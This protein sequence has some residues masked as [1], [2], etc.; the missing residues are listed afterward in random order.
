M[1]KHHAPTRVD[2]EGPFIAACSF[3]FDQF[4]IV[5]TMF[6]IDDINRLKEMCFPKEVVTIFSHERQSV[7]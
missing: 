5:T 4:F 1:D 7:R 2:C 6:Y 3:N